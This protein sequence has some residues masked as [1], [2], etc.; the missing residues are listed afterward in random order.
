MAYM[1]EEEMENT[2]NKKNKNI[3]NCFNSNIIN[4]KYGNDRFNYVQNI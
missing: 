1:D 4:F 3:N 2:Q